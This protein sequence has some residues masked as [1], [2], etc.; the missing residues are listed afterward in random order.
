MQFRDANHL[1]GTQ[2]WKRARAYVLARSRICWI[3]GHAGANSVDHI[4]PIAAGGD[5]LALANLA[6]A[7]ISCNSRKGKKLNVPQLKTSRQW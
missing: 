1:R 3:C 7:H 4:V 2:A 5:P 6:P